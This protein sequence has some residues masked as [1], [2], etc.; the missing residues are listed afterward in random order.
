MI[1]YKIKKSELKNSIY[2]PKYYNPE[3]KEELKR[4][5]S[6]YVLY[7][8]SELVAE[9]ILEFST[10]N[11]IGKMAYGTGDIPF[12]RTSDISNW[13]IKSLPKQGVSEEVYSEYKES[14]QVAIGDILLVRDGTYLIGTNCL[15]SKLDEKI[16]YQS[17]ILKIRIKNK[18]YFD[19]YL[20]FAII[21]TSIFQK[22]IRSVQFTADTIDTIGNRIYELYLPIPKSETEKN[23]ISLKIK[24]SLET[25]ELGKA[26]IKQ[27]PIIIED[28]L[29]SNSIKNAKSFVSKNIK[30]I[31][32]TLNQETV[33][34]EMNTFKVFS[35]M[36]SEILNRIYLP[37]FYDKNI[38]EEM[39][40]LKENCTLMTI[41]KLVKNGILEIKTGDEIGKMAYGTGSIPFIRT[42]D[43]SNLELK[44]D[45]KQ[46]VSEEIYKKY[47]EK[48]DV[49]AGDI[50]LV[51]DGTYLIGSS[52]IISD[53]ESK[54]LYCGG[55]YKI[56]VKENSDISKWLLLGL[57]NSYIVKK[58]IRNK[59]FTRDV[60]DTI[61]K[62]LF[63]V[64]LPIPKSSELKEEISTIIKN[65]YQS[66]I[67][68]RDDVKQ[69]ISSLYYQ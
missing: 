36:S 48:Q 28:T 67:K 8:I 68:A 56:R 49:Q 16:L 9:N 63:E 25:R 18:K 12:V 51:R 19:Q 21:N 1:A 14:Q 61:G 65:I 64:I 38:I 31:I 52:C 29:K 39:H 15:I 20:L 35:I 43:F 3:I 45:P 26:F 37:K 53:E 4:L 44:Y 34:S 10:G 42:S 17:H 59:Q 54:L 55:I 2:I 50:L 13:E 66:R 47:Y 24:A 40:K 7:K 6:K 41:D 60:I 22:Q 5:S 57:L 27:M 23:S 11:E 69:V 58:Q 33:T 46:G 62:R 32:P 30:D